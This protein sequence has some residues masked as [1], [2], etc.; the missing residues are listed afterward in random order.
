MKKYL[1]ALLLAVSTI[2]LIGCGKTETVQEEKAIAVSVQAAKGGD[3]ENTNTFSGITKIKEE[4]SVTVE[5]GGTIEEIN[6]QLGDRVTQGQTLLRVKGTDVE[7]GI[8]TAQAALNS[9]QAAYNDSD[10]TIANAQNQLESSLSNAKVS[11]D[12]ALAGY[13]ETKRQFDNTTELYN[14]GAVSEDVY[15]QAQAGLEQAQKS[16]EQAQAGLDAAQKSYDTGVSSREQAKA[17]IDQAQVAL[18]NALSNRDKLTLKS[19]V[20]GIITK[21]NFNVNEM[22]TQGQPAFVISSPDVLQVDLNITQ[23]DIE[24]FTEGQTVNVIIDG[25]TIE[26][27]VNYVP[28]VADSSSSLYKVEILVNNTEGQFKSGMSAEIEVSIEKESNVVTVPKKAVLEEDGTKYVYIVGDDNRAVKK[29]ITTGIET[30]STVEIK[31]GVD[32]DDT[33]VIGGLSLI[34]DNTK[35]FPVVKED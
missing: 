29:E 12:K 30:A 22:A 8:K 16:V 34:S 32:S 24:K 9:A 13:E 21:K 31:S 26:G 28:T 1:I 4:T 10:I 11:Y 5:M 15:K 19:P 33:V 18:D 3:I 35:L 27:T 6:V 25:Q 2:S 17:G 14:A 23:A 20:D 7:N